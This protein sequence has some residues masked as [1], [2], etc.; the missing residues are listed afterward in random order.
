MEDN[1]RLNPQENDFSPVASHRFAMRQLENA[2]YEH[3]DVE[4][5][6]AFFIPEEKGHETLVAFIVPRDDDL[7]EEAIMQFLTQSGQLEQENL[8]GAVKF[9]P[10]IPK[11][12]SGKVLKL[13]LLEDICT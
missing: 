10:R 5:V 12:P 9:V 7:T 6:A 1:Q 2:L 11:S 8:P 13:R 4:E 3:S